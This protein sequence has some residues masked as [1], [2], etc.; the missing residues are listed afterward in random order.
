MDA[1]LASKQSALE[2]HEQA[3]DI[4][5]EKLGTMEER[6]A[7]LGGLSKF[8]LSAVPEAPEVRARGPL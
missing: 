4:A 7:S 8:F 2:A 1:D 3:R 6:V 5:A